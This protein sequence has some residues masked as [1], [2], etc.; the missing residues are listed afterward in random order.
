MGH[1]AIANFFR[2]LAG[3][4]GAGLA[5]VLMIVFT[6]LSVFLGAVAL[7]TWTGWSL[8]LSI[9]LVAGG[10]FVFPMAAFVLTVCG[11]L[12]YLGVL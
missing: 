3:A 11:A 7:A 9:V 1:G 12:M 5:L 2:T 8:G 4:L 6:V 10:G